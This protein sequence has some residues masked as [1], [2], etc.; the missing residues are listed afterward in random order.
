MTPL[1]LAILDAYRA[2]H[3]L[4]RIKLATVRASVDA[5]S[6]VAALEALVEAGQLRRVPYCGL[7]LVAYHIHT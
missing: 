4:D 6:Y 1:M 5:E 3:G 7:G 2:P